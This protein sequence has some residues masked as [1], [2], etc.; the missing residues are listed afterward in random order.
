MSESGIALRET[1]RVARNRTVPL[2]PLHLARLT[3]GGCPRNALERLEGTVA[4]AIAEYTGEMSSR[5]RLTVTVSGD[6][7]FCATVERRLSSLDVVGGPRA[8]PVVMERLP[9]L[10]PGAAKP[11][12][13]GYWNA[14]QRVARAA[15]GDQ[16]I[17][18]DP[19]SAVIDGGTASIFCRHGRELVTP[20]APPAVAGVARAWVLENAAGF[21]YECRVASFGVASIEEADEVFFTNAFGGLREMRG[22]GGA[23]SEAL[24]QA[25]GA[26]LSGTT[27]DFV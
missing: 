16:A 25:L 9:E 15:D 26:V 11:A 24:G 12:D 17:L 20:L 27:D 8:V 6:D 1:C 2:W 3:A 22:R 14:A 21:G 4:G 13:R 10:P 18:V 7:S 5:V 19:D 23:A